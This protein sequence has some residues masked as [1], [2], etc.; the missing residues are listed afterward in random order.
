MGRK[1][2]TCSAKQKMEIPTY[3]KAW[4]VKTAFV[5]WNTHVFYFFNLA[6]ILYPLSNPGTPQTPLVLQVICTLHLF[7]DHCAVDL[8]AAGGTRSRE[9]Y[10][11]TLELLNMLQQPWIKWWWKQLFNLRLHCFSHQHYSTVFFLPSPLV[12]TSGTEKMFPLNSVCLMFNYVCLL[13]YIVK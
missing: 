8:Q 13:K 10:K 12:C 1:K 4:L 11:L 9:Y 3:T 2:L 5:C 6:I 7:L